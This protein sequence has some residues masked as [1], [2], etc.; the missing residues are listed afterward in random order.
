M[1]LTIMKRER[2]IALI[3]LGNE[4][5]LVG[6]ESTMIYQKIVLENIVIERLEIQKRL[7]IA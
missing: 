5:S 6:Y 1:R 2:A 3:E 7:I 4:L